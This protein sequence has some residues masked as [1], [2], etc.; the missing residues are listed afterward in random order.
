MKKNKDNTQNTYKYYL[1]DGDLPVRVIFNAQGLKLGAESPN[2][3][4]G[5]M[6]IKNTLLSRI[7]TSPDVSEISE[8][9]FEKHCHDLYSKKT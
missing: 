5:Q 6:A 8:D 2:I 7:E 9:T 4:T 1:L 3:D